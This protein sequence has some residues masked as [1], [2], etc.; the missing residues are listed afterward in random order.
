[1]QRCPGHGKG[2]KGALVNPGTTAASQTVALG[3]KQVRLGC[4]ER[5]RQSGQTQHRK[6]RQ[7]TH[8][9]DRATQKLARAEQRGNAIS[10]SN[11][12]TGV[13]R[14]WVGS[15]RECPA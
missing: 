9:T 6:T 2:T 14:Q 8:T 7:G 12:G 10:E 4:W 15:V 13:E 1:M 5:A 11:N 3:E